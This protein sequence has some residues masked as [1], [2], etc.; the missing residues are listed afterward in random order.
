MIPCSNHEAE[1]WQHDFTGS[2][3]DHSA[4]P[5]LPACSLASLPCHLTLDAVGL[6]LIPQI[7]TVLDIRDVASQKAKFL[8]AC[9]N[10]KIS[11]T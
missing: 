7:L 1:K 4:T 3:P 8:A 5:T 9:N 10:F 2:A 6:N 11:M